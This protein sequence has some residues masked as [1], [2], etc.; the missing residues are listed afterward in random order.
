MSIFIVRKKY[1]IERKIR[2]VN[3]CGFSRMKEGN[4]PLKFIIDDKTSIKNDKKTN[5]A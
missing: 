2:K 1:A 3:N 4:K 5:A